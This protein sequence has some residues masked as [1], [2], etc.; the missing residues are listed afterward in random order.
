VQKIQ[1]SKKCGVGVDN[2]YESNMQWL[3]ELQP[4]YRDADVRKLWIM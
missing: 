1:E 2:I 4:V 3:K